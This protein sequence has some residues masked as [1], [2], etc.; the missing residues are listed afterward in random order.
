MLKY[1]VSSCRSQPA[2]CLEHEELIC[3]PFTGSFGWFWTTRPHLRVAMAGKAVEAKLEKPRQQRVSLSMPGGRSWH[4]S[5]SCQNAQQIIM[6]VSLF[7]ACFYN[8]DKIMF[9]L[10]YT[11]WMTKLNTFNVILF[12]TVWISTVN[13]NEVLLFSRHIYWLLGNKV[14]RV[15]DKFSK[16]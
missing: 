10:Q 7:A 3:F 11:E 8:A 6:A 16:K 14:D 15:V 1:L 9:T 13:G 5:L 2:S 4:I 12:H